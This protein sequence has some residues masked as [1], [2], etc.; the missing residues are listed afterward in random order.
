MTAIPMGDIPSY[1][2]DALPD[3]RAALVFGEDVV[4]WR[5]LDRRARLRA[6]VLKDAGVR[7]DDLVT[8]S[9]PNGFDFYEFTF[10]I[11]RLGATPHVVSHR[12]PAAELAAILDTARPRL[13]VGAHDSLVRDFAAVDARAPAWSHEGGHDALKGP[14]AVARHWK[15]MSSGGS[16]G[17]PK[18]IVDAIP[19][20]MDPEYESLFQPRRGVIVNPGPLYHNAPFSVTHRALF[21]GSTVVGMARFDAL[22]TLRLIALH[23]ASWICLVPTMMARI[24]RLDPMVRDSFD[25]SCLTH[26]WHMASPMPHWLKEAW[27]S[28]LGP[29]RVWELYAG[30]EAQ[31]QTMISGTEWLA[32]RGSVGRPVR[33]QM[34]ILDDNGHELP[35]GEVGEIYMRPES[36][37]LTYHYLGAEARRRPDGFESLG[38]FGWMDQDGY[39]YIADRRTD[40]ILRGGANIYPAEVEAVLMEHPEVDVAVV[41]GLPDADL[42]ARVHAI[43]RP[44][45][46][47]ASIILPGEAA[48]RAFVAERLAAYKAPASYEFTQ[49]ELRDDAGKVRRSQLRAERLA[50]AGAGQAADS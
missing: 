29:E 26:V 27:I 31:G 18:I 35:H 5:E 43:V 42:G 38:D 28:W 30:T 22:E 44:R 14:S 1:Y 32:H 33:S 3:D 34:K 13:L 21:R 17:R 20:Q 25:L 23:R 9:L 46:P 6:A 2:A 47:A 49:A 12:L 8:L 24:W 4:T 7:R 37:S 36:A 10:A 48:L 15:A 19:A 50:Q 11:W 39:L 40:L 41:I 45:T 16:T